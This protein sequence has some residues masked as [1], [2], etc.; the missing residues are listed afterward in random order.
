MHLETINIFSI[1]FDIVDRTGSMEKFKKSSLGQGGLY[2]LLEIK[3][4]E[5]LTGSPTFFGHLY[6]CGCLLVLISGFQ[7]LKFMQLK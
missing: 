4:P 1:N 7:T 3:G 6:L 5:K 2:C